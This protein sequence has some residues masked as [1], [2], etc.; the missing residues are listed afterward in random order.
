MPEADR[1]AAAVAAIDAANAEDPVQL[2]VD[3]ARRA[4]ELVHA[5]V[6]ERWVRALDPEAD[7]LQLLAARAHHLR[8]WV[9]PRTDYPEGRA[10][11]LR[12]RRDHKERQAAEAGAILA[13][14]GY[15]PD[16]VERVGAIIAKRGLGTDPAVQ[17]HED[18]LCLT[19]LELQADPVAAQL[20]AE[21]TVEVLRKTL[22]KMSPAA[23][24]AA[25]RLALS[26]DAA[27]LLAA[28][29]GDPASPTL[30]PPPERK[31]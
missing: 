25:G 10:G 3:G 31:G 30:S 24:E 19:F 23:I 11:Y 6:V 4:K 15:R 2:E 14:H 16:E 22:V 9:V 17:V 5:D 21:R 13:E 28:A 1:F 20:G 8:R 18:A 7:E 26:P 29:V 12:W 27:A